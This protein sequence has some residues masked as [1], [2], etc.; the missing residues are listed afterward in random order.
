MSKKKKLLLLAT[1]VGIM[2][3]SDLKR[4]EQ[5]KY[6]AN[7]ANKVLEMVKRIRNVDPEIRVRLYKALLR[8]HLDYGIA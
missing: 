3:S 6:V 5:C 7:K 1:S 8:P 4:E 2:I